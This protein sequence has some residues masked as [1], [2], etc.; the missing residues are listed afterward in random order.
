[1][2]EIHILDSA[3]IDKIAAGEV[4]ERPVSVVKELVE[5]AVDA[6]AKHISV[7]IKEGGISMIRVTDDG[8]G[9]EK[10]QLP[11]VFYRHATSKIETAEDLTGV[12]SLGFRG[13]ALSSVAAVAKVELITKTEDELVGSRM[14][15]NGGKAE[16]PDEVG[17]PTGT[18]IVVR[19]LFFNTPVRKKFL[20][21]ANTEGS[22]VHEY[23]Q[24]LALG[25]P[26]VAFQ[27]IMNGQTRF[28]TSGNGDISEIIY[29]IWGKEVSSQLLPYEASMDGVTVRGY[30]GKPILA[31]ANRSFETIFVNT[32]FIKSALLSS[33][34][35]EGYRT[36]LMQHKYP[37]VVLHFAI[38]PQK[39]DVNVH[40]TKLDI[41]ITE[42]GE[43]LQMLATTIADT[44]KGTSLIQKAL[45]GDEDLT[46]QQKREQAAAEV[47]RQKEL[48]KTL[49]QPF[50]GKRLAEE[51]R[52]GK[53]DDT[54]SGES[55]VTSASG[56]NTA[57]SANGENTAGSANGENTTTSATG[58]NINNSASEESTESTLWSVDVSDS[59][60]DDQAGGQLAAAV[61]NAAQVSTVRPPKVI[62]NPVKKTLSFEQSNVIKQRDVVIIEKPQ[63]MELF[64][65]VDIRRQEI[66]NFKILGQVFDTY[67]IITM[68][69][70]LYYVDQH[71]AHEK[72]MYERLM[73][74]YREKEV[75]AQA[76]QPPVICDLTPRE[77]EAI[78][79]HKEVFASLGFEVEHFGED[80][81]ALRSVPL[82]LYGQGE[83]ELFLSALDAVLE[84]AHKKD[85]D[86]V[87]FKIAS[88]S[89]KAAVK[90]NSKLSYEEARALFEEMFACENPYHCPH[91][92]PTMISV[93]KQEM[94]KRFHR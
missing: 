26:N 31:R 35:E 88:M 87:L 54:A 2:A 76:L 62:G 49:A 13:E 52:Y 71:A 9:I 58:E 20:K 47:N 91:G 79:Q 41:R 74:H 81:Y 67:W 64:E 93:S 7:E 44:L 80:S 16:Q 68:G 10:S 43:L 6:G 25:S 77:V 89:C 40:P 85:A 23:M 30:L 24:H 66:D 50:E 59:G 84:G 55:T 36:L 57:G 11:K 22:Y 83:K 75:F 12:L 32:R 60:T 78:K 73:K 18:T 28:F 1:M 14:E 86:T 56:E 39:L 29:R 17:A 38:D 21:T 90:G 45:R 37:F 51:S 72:V 61:Q 19:D 15:I 33:A 34:I 42:P 94:E 53:T 3:T 82:D 27:F 92:R 4:V 70:K 63:Q 48:T 46:A 5:N 69:E 8:S 65:E